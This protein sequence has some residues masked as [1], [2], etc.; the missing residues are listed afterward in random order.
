MELDEDLKQLMKQLGMAI[1]ESLSDSESVSE[2]LTSIR[3]AGYDVFLM[4]EATIGFNKR[5]PE[6]SDAGE[7]QTVRA[8]ELLLTPQDAAFLKSLRITLESS[9]DLPRT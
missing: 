9:E 2:A 1:S 4:L 5:S 6:T 8:G 3:G 7:R